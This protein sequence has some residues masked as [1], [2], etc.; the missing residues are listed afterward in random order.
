MRKRVC[1]ECNSEMLRD[2]H[3]PVNT[4]VTD[5]AKSK[6][7]SVHERIK[8]H[9]GECKSG[10]AVKDFFDVQYRNHELPT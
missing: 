10:E 6:G 5:M 4:L 2:L 8:L 7:P 1:A 3:L 9:L